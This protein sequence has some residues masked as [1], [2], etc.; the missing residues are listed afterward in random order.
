MNDKLTPKLLEIIACPNC[1]GRLQYDYPNQRLICRFE[2]LAYPIENGVPRL[3][4]EHA[5]KLD[6]K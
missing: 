3:L 2:N 6:L 4:A 1:L 5:I